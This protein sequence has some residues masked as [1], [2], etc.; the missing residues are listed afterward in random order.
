MFC[1]NYKFGTASE[2]KIK[3]ILEIYLDMPLY[4]TKRGH[5]FDFTN[6][7]ENIYIELKTRRIYYRTF[8]KMIFSYYKYLYIKRNP[9]NKYYIV[10]KLLDGLFIFKYRRNKIEF[11]YIGEHILK[12]KVCL[13][14]RK[15]LKH[16]LYN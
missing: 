10:Y 2:R 13:I 4:F 7:E 12:N 9:L 11:G 5:N 15:H 14:H 3:P 6:K 8:K 1:K 16:V